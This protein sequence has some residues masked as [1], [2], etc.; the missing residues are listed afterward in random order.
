VVVVCGLWLRGGGKVDLTLDGAA[1]A[2]SVGRLAGL[3]AAD[4]LLIQVLLMARV[5]W[6]E[7]GYG[8][9]RLARW[10]RYVGFTSFWL[11]LAHVLFIV[12]GYAGSAHV[13]L[14]RESVDLTLN[15]PAMLMAVAG[16]GL[17]VGVAV[18]SIRAARRR[19]RYESWHLLHLYAYAGVGLAL[20][21]QL[22]TGTDFIASGLARAY[23]WTL[24]ALAAVAILV[25]R[26]ALPLRRSMRHRL[27]VRQVRWESADVFS[28][29]LVGRDLH[30][31]PMRAGQFANWRFLT[32]TGW[33][34]AH[35]YSL[36]AL[37]RRDQLRIT[38]RAGGDDAARIATARPGTRV[39]MEG[40]YGRLT[41]AVRTRP[42]LLFLAAG[43]G[44]TPLR[45]LLEELPYRPGDADL[46]YRANTED[47][48]ALRAELD[49]IAARRG[50]RIHYLSGPPPARSSWLPASLAHLSDVDILR[51]IALDV[52]RRDVYLCGP[53]PWMDA[54]RAAL[55]E[56]EVPNSNIHAEDFAW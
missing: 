2:S 56:A 27:R 39:L 7:R 14:V 4:L 32:G 53:A 52:A 35:P 44:I 40:P 30:Q 19:L 47:G 46:V 31:L 43:I 16:T 49:R 26:I 36:S 51:R 29:H 13:G 55:W 50:A 12:V 38:V 24:W 1:A 3:L 45:A 33:M 48:F 41:A 42:R 22:W 23:W 6:V 11:M 28:V 21:H 17:L 5:P 18:L 9:D 37:P 20:P 34:R 25:Y 15:Y 54:V 8:Q 10:H